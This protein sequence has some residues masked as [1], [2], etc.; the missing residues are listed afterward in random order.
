MAVDITALQTNPPRDAREFKLFK[1]KVLVRDPLTVTGIMLHQTDVWYG[2]TKQ[3]V[4]DAGGDRHEALHRRALHIPA[5][6]TA[7]DGRKASLCGHAVHVN[8]LR[9]YAYHGHAANRMSLGIECEGEYAGLVR[10]AGEQP[11]ARLIQAGRDA[12]AYAVTEGRK[13]G[14]PIEFIWAHRQSAASRRRD[15]GE[16]LWRALVVEYAVP[17]L[18]LKTQPRRT[19]GDGRAIPLSWAP[20]G[21]G[22]W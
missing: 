14:M 2:L 13:L 3:Q 12:I 5:H 4:R 15:P 1:G 20:D 11:S 16:A 6:L 17:V 10:M 18:G 21:H 9:W 22:P 7:F 8:P 19:W